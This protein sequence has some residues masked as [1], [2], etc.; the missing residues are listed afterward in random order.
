[1]SPVVQP[2]RRAT[3]I[4]TIPN[5]PGE[6][7][8]ARILPDV[9]WI[10]QK[11]KVKIT[12]GFSLDPVHAAGGEH[13]LGLAVDVVP[14]ASKGG[15]WDDVDR[16]VAWAKGQKAFRWIGYDGD[17]GHGRGNHAHLSW[18]HTASGVGH[19]DTGGGGDSFLERV[20]KGAAAT[21]PGVGPIIGGVLAGPDAVAAAAA[22][23][24]K[25]AVGLLA[26]A[27]GE[28]GAR[29]LL[30]VALI[31]GGAAL[32]TMGL[33]RAFGARVDPAALAQL[34]ITKK[35]ATKGAA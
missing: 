22:A 25:A 26:D 15:T 33:A 10:K 7:I 30:Y 13:P 21:V 3:G 8:D 9:E 17:P 24:I 6:K 11:F 28:K 5:Q 4:V 18:T 35:P 34:A 23:P 2:R 14:D 27:L 1:M 29:I 16:M 32:A 12:D 20:G 19:I 31:V